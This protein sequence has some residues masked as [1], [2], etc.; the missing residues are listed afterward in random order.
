MGALNN[1][2]SLLQDAKLRAVVVLVA[3]IAVAGSFIGFVRLKTSD[4]SAGAGQEQGQTSVTTVGTKD[5]TFQPGVNIKDPQLEQKI[6][7]QDIKGVEQAGGQLGDSYVPSLASQVPSDCAEEYQ[8]LKAEM[9]AQKAKNQELANNLNKLQNDMRNSAAKL[10]AERQ[11]LKDAIEKLQAARQRNASLMAN[12]SQGASIPDGAL[13]VNEQQISNALNQISQQGGA[14]GTVLPTTM[15]VKAGKYENT[16][17]DTSSLDG[18]TGDDQVPPGLLNQLKAQGLINPALLAGQKSLTY[19]QLDKIMSQKVIGKAGDILIGTIDNTVNSDTTSVVFAHI[20]QGPL[21][22]S[23]L[24]GSFQPNSADD[25]LILNFNTINM[26]K[27]THTY[28]FNGVAIDPDTAEAALATSV[29]HHYLL[30]YGTFFAATFLE[31]LTDALTL[32]KAGFFGSGIIINPTS[33][34]NSNFSTKDQMVYAL[35]NVGKKAT[36]QLQPVFNRKP[37]IVVESGTAV[38]I[39]LT[40]DVIF[41]EP[42]KTAQKGVELLGNNNKVNKEAEKKA[43]NLQSTTESSAVKLVEKNL[44]FVRDD[45]TGE[46]NNG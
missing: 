17:I 19:N 2:R 30:R 26:P 20:T 8:K 16:I 4:S 39:L 43:N 22:G 34:N 23:K 10:A 12:N 1:L 25:K 32:E 36:Q 37:T 33:N 24:I 35:G 44:P 3:I 38:G 31:G 18:A 13:K 41:G 7:N 27:A 15:E 11:Q 28:G 14:L 29:D 40:Q 42:P 9:D 46:S 6:K 45:N 21:S 5:L